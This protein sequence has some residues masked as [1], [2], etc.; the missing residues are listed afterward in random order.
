MIKKLLIGASALALST[1]AVFAQELGE[2][3]VNTVTARPFAPEATYLG[4]FGVQ[5]NATTA[6]GA[7]LNDATRQ[8]GDKAGMAGSVATAASIVSGVASQAGVALSSAT[9]GNKASVDQDGPNNSANVN[10]LGGT[11]GLAVVKQS[12][13]TSQGNPAQTARVVQSD[14]DA[15]TGGARNLAFIQQ[16][17]TSANRPNSGENALIEQN[18][19][20]AAG[21]GAN[22][23]AVLQG[24]FAG[25]S[26]TASAR[27]DRGRISQDG[28]G[29]DGVIAQSAGL[30][31]D[32]ADNDA[33][34]D[35]DGN[36]NR[37]SIQQQVRANVINPGATN[38]P[39]LSGN[40]TGVAGI[41]QEGDSHQAYILQ[42]GND[43]HL[44]ASI[45]Q[46]VDGAGHN[47]NFAAISQQITNQNGGGSSDIAISNISQLGS[48][49]EAWNTQ[50]VAGTTS[51]I[52][53]E[54]DSNFAEVR[55][56]ARASSVVDQDGGNFNEAYVTQEL[57]AVGATASVFQTG[58]NNL[59]TVF[60]NVAG[61][62]GN[63]SQ[64]GGGNVAIVRQ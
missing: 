35:Q 10:Q 25:A 30:V 18:Q 13:Q 41:S 57:A 50:T 54:G 40:L 6:N 44:N 63:I 29:N 14:E 20:A 61:D 34:I 49:N 31:G 12:N 8:D 36:G 21:F 16:V 15:G 22:S 19:V 24:G 5:D 62:I 64:N 46:G 4:K 42:N 58:S 27:L 1:T 9:A 45:I 51:D 60:Q 43:E 38:N 3:N 7:T 39:A 55:Q 33:F 59:G 2:A 52:R 17:H 23:A 37:A 48:F 28:A 56:Y 32:V 26:Q 53:Q 11:N 47:G